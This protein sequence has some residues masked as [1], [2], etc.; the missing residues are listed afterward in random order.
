MKDIKI[1]KFGNFQTIVLK[2]KWLIKIRDDIDYTKNDPIGKIILDKDGNRLG[3]VLDIIGNV[4][5]PY[6]LIKPFPN[7]TPSEEVYLEMIE[8]RR[9]KR[10]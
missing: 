3:K 4:K 5:N 1:I 2:D 7:S 8:R 6:A 10:K 9:G